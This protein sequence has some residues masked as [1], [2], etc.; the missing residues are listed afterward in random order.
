LYVV[1]IPLIFL[2]LGW[3]L[4]GTLKN[5]FIERLEESLLA[6]TKLIT[7]TLPPLKRGKNL[8]SLSL[9]IK[10]KTGARVTIILRD[11]TVLG[12]SDKA[13]ALMDNHIH[14]PEIQQALLRGKGSSIRYSNTVKKNM[15]YLAIP[16]KRDEKIKGFLRLAHPMTEI[17]NTLNTIRERIIIASFLALAI[18]IITGLYLSG[19]ITRRINKITEVTRSIAKGDFRRKLLMLPGDEIGELCENINIMAKELETKMKSLTREKLLLETIFNTMHDGLLVIDAKCNIVIASPSVSRIFGISEN[20]VG[21][22]F[23][24]VLRETVFQD[25]L[26]EAK[27]KGKTAFKE[28]EIF[29]P[30]HTHLYITATQLQLE[31]LDAAFVLLIHDITRIKQLETVRKDFVANV[32]HEIRTPITAIRGFAETLLDSALEDREKTHKYLEIIKNHSERLA[33]LVNDL[34]TLSRLDKKE[35]TLHPE[36]INLRELIDHIFLTLREKALSKDIKL[37]ND[38]PEDFQSIEADRQGFTQVFLNLIDNAIKFTDFGKVIVKGEIEDS[39][40]RIIVEDT[41][42]GI[43]AKHIPR[44][45]ERFYRVDSSR[46][47]MLGGT[48]LGLAIVKHLVRAHGWK[49]KIESEPGKGTKVIL[50]IPSEG[51]F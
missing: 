40:I 49:M 10:K 19:S 38:I 25:I 39:V 2:L 33:N 16:I 17:E 20:I 6:Q 50:I 45:G 30:K 27:D 48:G 12:D 13:S 5:Y 15:L 4:S 46:S 31:I 24:E 35:F 37:I 8:D 11:G 44:L 28:A 32:S 1:L 29:H 22:P 23:F 36:K 43:E 7:D 51:T 18:S 34:L 14:R 9:E 42:I 21:R 26:Q 47:R 3:Y 41:G